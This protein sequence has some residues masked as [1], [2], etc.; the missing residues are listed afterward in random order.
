MKKCI[1]KIVSHINRIFICIFGGMFYEKQNNSYF[2]NAIDCD[3]IAHNTN[4]Y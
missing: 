1:K 2:Y 3:I 4:L